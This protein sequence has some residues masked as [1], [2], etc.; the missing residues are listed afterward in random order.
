[1]TQQEILDKINASTPFQHPGPTQIDRIIFPVIVGETDSV[2]PLDFAVFDQI[3]GFNI[4]TERNLTYSPHENSV[5]FD[6]HFVVK[7]DK[8]IFRIEANEYPNVERVIIPL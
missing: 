8:V 4:A 5:L 7:D 1:M 2:P 6:N 3:Q